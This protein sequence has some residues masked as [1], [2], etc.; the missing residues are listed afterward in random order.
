MIGI[1]YTKTFGQVIGDIT[2]NLDGS[3]T[4]EAPCVVQLGQTQIALSPLLA[5]VEEKVVTL[6][7]D[8]LACPGIFTAIVDVRNYYSQHYGSSGIQLVTTPLQ[9]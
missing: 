3:Y 5:T 2:E 9:K 1:L 6:G 7:K 4:V 8:E